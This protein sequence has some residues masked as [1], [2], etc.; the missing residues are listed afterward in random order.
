MCIFSTCF[1]IRPDLLFF[2]LPQKISEL[3]GNSHQVIYEG[4]KTG[5][6]VV[7]SISLPLSRL[8]VAKWQQV[9][10]FSLSPP[11]LSPFSMAGGLRYSFLTLRSQLK[12]K[13][14]DEENAPPDLQR[15]A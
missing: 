3:R 15:G 4:G 10:V 13:P 2:P 7:L 1:C 5:V 9:L 6:V 11:S 12:P 8:H 14:V